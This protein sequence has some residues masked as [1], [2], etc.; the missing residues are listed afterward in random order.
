MHISYGMEGSSS[1]N[2]T[3]EKTTPYLRTDRIILYNSLTHF[4]NKINRLLNDSEKLQEKSAASELLRIELY[5]VNLNLG[6]DLYTLPSSSL[7]SDEELKKRVQNLTSKEAIPLATSLENG[8]NQLEIIDE[9]I[10]E[11]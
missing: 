7:W 1:P 8:L 10:N 2:L 9:L 3:S 11:F 4:K 5:R 6:Y